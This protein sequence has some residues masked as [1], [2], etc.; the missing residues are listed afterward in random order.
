MASRLASYFFADCADVQLH[1]VLANVND[2][3]DVFISTSK[4]K[5]LYRYMLFDC[6]RTAERMFACRAW[7]I[8]T[9]DNFFII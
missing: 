2:L 7:F 1:R 9:I 4:Y 6:H 8:Y 5:E 3:G